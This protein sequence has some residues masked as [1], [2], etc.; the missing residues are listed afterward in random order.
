[1]TCLYNLLPHLISMLSIMSILSNLEAIIKALICS[2]HKTL[3]YCVLM[4]NVMRWPRKIK[5]CQR[6][7][8]VETLLS[9][10]E[11]G[12]FSPPRDILLYVLGDVIILKLHFTL[13]FFQHFMGHWVYIWN[14]FFYIVCITFIFYALKIFLL[15]QLGEQDSKR[16]VP[17]M[18]RTVLRYDVQVTKKFV[19]LALRITALRSLRNHSKL[20]EVSSIYV[21]LA[22]LCLSFHL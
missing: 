13:V 4:N 21:I 3:I 5:G 7:W 10:Q 19:D 20:L 14:Q 9:S 17:S 12:F 2:N 22:M 11:A 8:N 16:K 18:L 6:D 15:F 1:M